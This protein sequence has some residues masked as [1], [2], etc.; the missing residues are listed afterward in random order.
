M[1][2]DIRFTISKKL[3]EWECEIDDMKD[4]EDYAYNRASDWFES[5]DPSDIDISIEE[6]DNG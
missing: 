6:V 1:Q 2:Y 3:P 5:L 4:A